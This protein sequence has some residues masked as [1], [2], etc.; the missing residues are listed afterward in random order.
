MED[1]ECTFCGTQLSTEES[2]C[3]ECGKDIEEST[4]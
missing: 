1:R 4:E 3:S 2:Y